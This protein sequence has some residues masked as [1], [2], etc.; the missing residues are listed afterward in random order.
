[1]WCCMYIYRLFHSIEMNV[2]NVLMT[3]FFTIRAYHHGK[4]GEKGGTYAHAFLI[5]IK[6]AKNIK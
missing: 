2:F 1:M 6:I 5:S 4:K 3:Y